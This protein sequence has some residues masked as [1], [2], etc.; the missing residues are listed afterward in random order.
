MTT[1]HTTAVDAD[2]APGRSGRVTAW[3]LTAVAA[4]ALGL[5]ATLFTDL[6][7][8]AWQDGETTRAVVEDVSRGTAHASIVLGYLAVAALV[9][10]AASWRRRVEPRVT[11]STAARV[12]P[13]GLLVAAGALTL[14]YG[15]KGMF[16]V[17]G[18]GGLN[19]GSF[20]QDGLYVMYVLN[21]FGSFVGWLGVTIAAGAVAWMALRER[22]VS[23]W[24]GVVSV[25]PVLAVLGMTIGTGL[26]GFPGVVMPLWLVVAGLGLALGR[27]PVTR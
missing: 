27:S 23:R 13:S 22:T 5:G 21:D 18:E 3:P 19:A 10:L 17:Y 24:I 16:A 1:T 9:V 25:L 26:P 15:Y 20:D 11:G 12:V 6:H 2:T 8:A 4:G 7:P 14:G